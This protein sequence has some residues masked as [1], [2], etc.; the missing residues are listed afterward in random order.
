MFKRKAFLVCAIVCSFLLIASMLP[1]GL[2]DGG[3]NHRVRNMRF[4]VSGG[5]VNDRSNAF[6]C[7]GTLGAL[8]S[9]GSTRY[10]LS[11]NHV[12]GISGGANVGDDVSQPGLIDSNCQVATVVGDFAGS[13]ALGASN[14]D[15]AVATLRAGQMDA[16]GFIE[17]IGVPSSTIALPAIGLG[18]AKS[19]RTT[20]FTTG[21]I[22]SINTSVSVQYQQGC[23]KGKKFTVSF[24]NQI[25]ISSST[26][27][28]GGDSGSLIVTNNA[29]HNP[30]GLLFAGSS[31]TTIANPI[32]LV[33]T[34]LGAAM[35][36]TFSFN[37]GGGAAA[38][39]GGQ[40]HG[41]GQ[42]QESQQP[43]IPGLERQMGMLPQQA[44]DRALG[45]L[46]QH[47]AN[48][49]FLPGVMGAGIGASGREDGEAGIVIYV[50]KDSQTR[51]PLP[52]SIDGIPVVVVLTDQFIAY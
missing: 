25:V 8:I 38:P 51:P 44:A 35:G 21:T 32:G 1:A 48:L 17:D 19:G 43:F 31:T 45:V 2:A 27:S 34:R 50:N 20:G 12:L 37:L 47:R 28:A 7:S 26:F 36:R 14:V 24:T 52:D 49:M 18:V 46:E 40:G 13:A 41:R 22:S 10:I 23:G 42:T 11:N 16:T 9:D 6:C 4:G 33:L 15:A 5:N 30:V 3:P 29:A 39:S